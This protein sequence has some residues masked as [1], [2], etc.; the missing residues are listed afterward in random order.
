[1]TFNFEIN[2][3]IVFIFIIFTV[4]DGM[5]LNNFFILPEKCIHEGQS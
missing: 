1:M 5:Y 3:Q 4:L 2:I